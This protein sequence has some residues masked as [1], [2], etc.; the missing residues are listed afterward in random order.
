MECWNI[1]STVFENQGVVADSESEIMVKYIGD[2]YKL[3]VCDVCEKQCIVISSKDL[4][5]LLYS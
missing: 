4:L 2:T 5:Y 1:A 3:L